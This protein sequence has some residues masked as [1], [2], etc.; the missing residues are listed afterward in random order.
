MGKVVYKID[1]RDFATL[2][3]FY[4]LVGRVSIPGAKWGHNLD[5]FNDIL[6]GSSARR[7]A[8]SY[9]G[10]RTRRCLASGWAIRRPCGNSIAG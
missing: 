7:T 10:G 4:G 9:C 3:E 8:G 6:H 5:A 2:E 1:G